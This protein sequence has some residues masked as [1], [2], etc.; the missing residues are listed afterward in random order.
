MIREARV[1]GALTVDRDPVG[2]LLSR[3]SLD[4]IRQPCDISPGEAI[5]RMYIATV[6]FRY[7]K[8]YHRNQPLETG[9]IR[10]RAEIRLHRDTQVLQPTFKA[11]DEC[12]LQMSRCSDSVFSRRVYM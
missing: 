9:E 10:L 12:R 11:L 4:L 1:D 2:G 8:E 3:S 7:L 6:R 5:D